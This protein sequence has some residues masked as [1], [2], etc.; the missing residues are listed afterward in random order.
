MKASVDNGTLKRKTI[1]TI[2]K[3]EPPLGPGDVAN[4]RVCFSLN[5]LA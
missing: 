2:S 5:V 3:T 1:F 4:I